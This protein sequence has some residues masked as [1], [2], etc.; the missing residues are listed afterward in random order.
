[1]AATRNMLVATIDAALDRAAVFAH[2]AHKGYGETALV[3]GLFRSGIP[4]LRR[5]LPPV[6]VQHGRRI[7][8]GGVFCHGNTFQV[9]MQPSSKTCEIGD[10]LIV[11]RD[12]SAGRPRNTALLLQAK[13]QRQGSRPTAAQRRLYE[14][15]PQFSWTY[16]Q[17]AASGPRQVMTAPHPGAQYAYLE[18]PPRRPNRHYLRDAHRP[19]HANR[20]AVGWALAIFGVEGRRF[21]NLGPA[22]NSIGWSRVVWDMI[23]ATAITAARRHRKLSRGIYRVGDAPLFLAQAPGGEELVEAWPELPDVEGDDWPPNDEDPDTTDVE[24]DPGG[25]ISILEIRLETI[26]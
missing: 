8:I 16:G 4:F 13:L 12:E 5:R 2:R 25:A 14:S 7:S 17:L 18:S 6:M 24:D 22:Q 23:D 26:P 10:L 3:E 20:L 1:M 19:A 9:T 11:V 21:D 15:W